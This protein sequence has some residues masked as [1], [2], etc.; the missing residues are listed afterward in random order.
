MTR[1][2]S[3]DWDS[4]VFLIESPFVGDLVRL[5]LVIIV[6]NRCVRSAL[7]LFLFVIY[8]VEIDD[9]SV[10]IKFNSQKSSNPKVVS[11]MVFQWIS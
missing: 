2:S 8:S 9:L 5:G 7:R 6:L 10:Q 1:S 11:N 3:E 4:R